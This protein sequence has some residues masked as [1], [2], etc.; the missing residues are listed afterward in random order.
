MP[1][2]S[3]PTDTKFDSVPLATVV[4]PTPSGLPEELVVRIRK[5]ERILV[6]EERPGRRPLHL[7][8]NVV[9]NIEADRG[10]GFVAVEIGDRVGQIDSDVVLEGQA[11]DR[12]R[13]IECHDLIA[14]TVG[15]SSSTSP[16][17][18]K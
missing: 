10:G 3:A 14:G 8:R 17:F 1:S 4:W 18:G 12:P 7:R 9:V 15:G 2:S 11:G 6:H 16:E 13:D 5:R